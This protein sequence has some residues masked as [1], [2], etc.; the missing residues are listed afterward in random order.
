[1]RKCPFCEEQIEDAS[2][3]C[4][5]CGSNVEVENAEGSTASNGEESQLMQENRKPLSNGLKVLLTMI[6]TIPLLGQLV[7]IIMAIIYM[8]SEGDADRKSFGK[9]LLIG[10]LVIFLV[11]CLCCIA[12][13]VFAFYFMEQ[14]GPEF[15]QEFQQ[16][17]E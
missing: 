8:N 1:M 7:G 2:S 13:F 4:P 11:A 6:A 17:Y 16:Y 10:T 14:M 15:F 5:F 9:A 3:K 12:Y